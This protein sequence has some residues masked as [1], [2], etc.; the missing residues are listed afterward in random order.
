MIKI[1]DK[2]V[3]YYSRISALKKPGVGVIRRRDESD[4]ELLKRFRKKFSKSGIIKELKERVYYEKP[5]DK[6]RR[7]KAQSIRNIRREEEKAE[8]L[9]ERVAKKKKYYRKKEKKQNANYSGRVRQNRSEDN[10]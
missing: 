3:N 2:K 1:K 10:N 9:L 7:K 5:S 4:E 6:R 8:K